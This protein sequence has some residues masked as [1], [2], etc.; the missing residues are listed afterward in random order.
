VGATSRA[1]AVGVALL[2]GSGAR[3]A[4]AF[5]VADQ[6][7]KPWTGAQVFAGGPVLVIGGAKRRTTEF[8]KAWVEA[9]RGTSTTPVF[10]I[11]NLSGLPFFI[12]RGSVRKTMRELLPST[13]VLCD[14]DG[15]VSRTLG[16]SE[17][18]SVRLYGPG[19]AVLIELQE[20]AS[21]AGVERLLAAL[22][23]TRLAVDA[24]GLNP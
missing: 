9:L 2:A 15:Q 17:E 21:A 14:Y 11:A 3:A 19:G 7:E 16:L 12:P 22:P 20:E 6:N 1:L 10:G 23:R 8:T 4:P 5:E 18:N 13:P 24:G